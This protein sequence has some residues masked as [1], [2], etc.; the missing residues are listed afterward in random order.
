[1][2]DK[3]QRSR[4]R[5]RDEGC[6][7]KH[8]LWKLSLTSKL[9]HHTE[10]SKA[11]ECSCADSARVKETQV[12]S[13][14]LTFLCFPRDQKPVFKQEEHVLRHVGALQGQP[15]VLSDITL[16]AQELSAVQELYWIWP[17]QVQLYFKHEMFCITKH[18]QL[19]LQSLICFVQFWFF[20]Y[21]SI[22]R[23]KGWV[24]SL[25]EASERLIFKMGH[26]KLL[27]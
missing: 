4:K 9:F 1:M 27:L 23:E 17:A 10:R 13:E 6:G 18:V 21:L 16:S 3:I 26:I 19:M 25:K 15:E 24:L 7:G 2:K 12:T 8:I 22:S 20:S 14:P 5:L 11:S